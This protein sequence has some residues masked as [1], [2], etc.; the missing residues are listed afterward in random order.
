MLQITP[1]SFR[2][3]SRLKS[4]ILLI[5]MPFT[6]FFLCYLAPQFYTENKSTSFFNTREII[7]CIKN[8]MCVML[9]S[10]FIHSFV[11]KLY[12]IPGGRGTHLKMGYGYVLPLRP[13][14]TPSL[15]FPKTPISWFFSSSRSY[16]CL[17]SQILENLH[18][19]GVLHPWG[20]FLKTLCIFSKNK[21]T[22]DKVSYGSG[23]KCSKKLKNH[24]FT[25]VET[26]VVKLQWK[27]CENQYFPCFEP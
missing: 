22:S 5:Q 1:A 14:F 20:L 13:P 4:S 27:I 23:Q 8:H 6:D 10:N 7:L 25:S 9:H 3:F 19:K 2:W 26:I 21:A 15:P 16:I 11:F 18:F 12:I 24:S 17:K